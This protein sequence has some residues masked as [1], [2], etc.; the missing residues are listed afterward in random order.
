MSKTI[1]V[2][3]FNTYLIKKVVKSSNGISLWA[4]DG[5][6]PDKYPEYPIDADV[7]TAD[8]IKKDWYIEES[9]IYGGFNEPETDLGVRAYSISDKDNVSRSK[10]SLIYSGVLNTRTDTNRTNVFS[11]A[12]DI[13]KSLD[14]KYGGIDRLYADDDTM[15]ILQ[16]SKVSSI[17]IDKDALYTSEGNRNVTSSNLFL[18]DVTQY[19][20]NYGTGGF[21]E[22][23]AVDG[24]R[25]YFADK[26]NSSIMRL[27]LDGLT[28]IS[29]YGMEDYF[30]DQFKLISSN[31]KREV[32]DVS[33]AIPWSATTNQLTVSGENIGDIEYGMKV[34]NISGENNLYIIDIGTPSNNQVIITLNRDISNISSPQPSIIQITKIVKDRVVGGYDNNYDNYALSIHRF[35]PSKSQGSSLINIPFIPNSNPTDITEPIP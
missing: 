14:P 35:P 31:L 34:E 25:K 11:I 7:S 2:K 22:S 9:R 13:T 26:S 33:W 15:I 27:S 18:G 23:F 6:N 19:S 21:P 4:G 29:K 24:N 17:L 28:E 5:A 8:V 3:Y 16:E 30:R 20:G 10:N 1:E 12:E 32:L